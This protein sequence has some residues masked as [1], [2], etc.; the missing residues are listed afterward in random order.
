MRNMGFDSDAD[1]YGEA[2]DTIRRQQ[3]EI[4]RL[5]AIVDKLPKTKDGVPVPPGCDVWVDPESPHCCL[6]THVRSNGCIAIDFHGH[7]YATIQTSKDAFST[8]E[9]AEAAGGEK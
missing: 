2:A 3:E 5:R 7:P 8:R 9:A 4:E 6:V 1:N